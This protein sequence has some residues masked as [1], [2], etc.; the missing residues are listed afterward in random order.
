MGYICPTCGKVRTYTGIAPDPVPLGADPFTALA[1]FTRWYVANCVRSAQPITDIE[2]LLGVVLLS[3]DI[4]WKQP[5][6]TEYAPI[7][8]ALRTLLDFLKVDRRC[9]VTYELHRQNVR[10]AAIK[11]ALD[12]LARRKA[13]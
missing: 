3:F 12:E 6:P 1:D 7:D 8:D 11:A 13:S 5:R 10:Q 9:K 4:T 2:D